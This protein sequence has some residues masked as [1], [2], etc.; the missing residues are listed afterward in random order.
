MV[1]TDHIQWQTQSVW[2]LWTRN[3]PVAKTSTWQHTTFARDRLPWSRWDSDRSPRKRV[4]ADIGRRR[5][6]HSVL[7][8]P[9]VA[10]PLMFGPPPSPSSWIHCRVYEGLTWSTWIHFTI[11]PSLPWRSTLQNSLPST[12]RFPL[13]F[14]LVTFYEQ[15]FVRVFIHSHACY[16]LFQSQPPWCDH[17]FDKYIC[18]LP[19]LEKLHITQFARPPCWI[20]SQIFYNWKCLPRKKK[21]V[22]Q[23]GLFP[24][25]RKETSR[26]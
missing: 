9:L 18:W 26:K 17:P 4:A 15:N 3:R 11:S 7:E 22:V 8:K 23:Y 6:A 24:G 19:V 21:W 25:N 1:A 2:L 16:T 20:H 14:L 5:R 12:S 13:W 10:E